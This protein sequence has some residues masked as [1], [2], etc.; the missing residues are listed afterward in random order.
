VLL[1]GAGLVEIES[2]P[3]VSAPAAEYPQLL[4]AP[5]AGVH[6]SV[7]SIKWQRALVPCHRRHTQSKIIHGNCRSAR[8][9]KSA[10]RQS[11]VGFEAEGE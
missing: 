8:G 9:N 5:V 3:P 1:A 4:I 6:A 2:V 10:T 7:R 11:V